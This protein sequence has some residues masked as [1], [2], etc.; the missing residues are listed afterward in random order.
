MKNCPIS[1]VCPHYESGDNKP[2]NNHVRLTVPCVKF[3]NMSCDM[4]TSIRL[5]MG[6]TIACDI[7]KIKRIKGRIKD[8]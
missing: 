5:F 4:A 6:E 2:P 7:E 1:E 8:G 3:V